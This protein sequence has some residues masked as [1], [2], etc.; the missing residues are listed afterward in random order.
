MTYLES[1][2][3]VISRSIV[4]IAIQVR[5]QHCVVGNNDVDVLELI[6]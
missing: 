5:R 1:V 6:A 4:V 3:V 2:I